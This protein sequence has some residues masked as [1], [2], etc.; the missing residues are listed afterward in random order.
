MKSKQTL[1]LFFAIIALSVSAQDDEKP[2]QEI[3]N[4]KALKAY[5]E[6]IDKKNKK[7]ERMVF[8]RKALDLEPDYAE[9]NFAYASE[10][11]K[12]LSIENAA[13]KV[14][15]PYFLKV[16]EFCPKYHADP[17]F[18]VGWSYYEQEKWEECVKYLKDFLKFKSDDDKKFNKNYEDQL[19]KA[20]KMLYWA[21]FYAEINKNTV[22]FEPYAVNGVCTEVDEYLPS[23]SPDNQIIFFTRKQP[24]IKRVGEYIQSDREDE[25]FFKSVRNPETGEFDKGK[26]MPYPFNSNSNE[27]GATVS[28]DNNHLYFTVSKNEGGE[29]PNFDIYFSDFIN[30]EW[31]KPE[32]VPEI[33]DPIAWDSQPTLASDGK[34]LYFCSD[35]KG[36]Y[37]GVDIYKT[38]RD[39]KTGKWSAPVNAGRPIN[40][41]GNEYAPFLHSDFQSLYFSSDGHPSIGGVDVFYTHFG[42]DGKW[43]E[44]KNLGIPINTTGDDIGFFVSTDGRYAYFASNQASRGKGRGKGK[45]DIYYF[46][47]YKEV[48]PEEVLLI[49]GKVED[50]ATK[51][52][53]NFTVDIKDAVTQK[54]TDAVVDTLTGEYTAI[55]CVKNKND[56]IVTVKKDGAA[57]S[58]QLIAKEEVIKSSTKKDLVIAKTSEKPGIPDK[59][60]IKVAAANSEPKQSTIL[61]PVMV[62]LKL[63]TLKVGN[64]YTINNIYYSTNSAELDPR[65]IIVIDEFAEYLKANPKI[66]IEIH[67]HTDNVGNEKDN[68]TLSTNRALTVRDLLISKGVDASKIIAYK[69]FG[70][71]RPVADNATEEGKRKNRRTEFLIVSK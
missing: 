59:A 49:K 50:N 60:G 24:H 6:G 28:V 35:R 33:N 15:E 1:L 11:I 64:A 67:G 2:C 40:T 42:E 56:L 71:S 13:Y 5:K 68:L 43:S 27:G 4:K 66:K 65:S 69:G 46:E 51:G 41:N 30:G 47:L 44:P 45:F 10:R 31:T 22:P 25:F 36:G 7:E 54:K 63:D 52:S 32:K 14:V 18:Y 58:S 61:R 57:F 23:I 37:G 38:V 12:T 26:P 70:A 29:Q 16:I 3:T 20:K 55:V 19:E 21:K 9:A 17:Y 53:K 48:R 39:M 62:D 8:L 34:T